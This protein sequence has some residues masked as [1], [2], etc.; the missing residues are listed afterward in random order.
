[1]SGEP[2]G[3]VIDPS[4]GVFS[5]T[6]DESQGPGGYSFVV[7][8]SDG[9]YSTSAAVKLTVNEVPT[10]PVIT[11]LGD[12]PMNI[13]NDSDPY[14]FVEPGY[15]AFDAE[16]GDLTGSVIVSGFVQM[17][18]NGTY[19]LTYS[20]TDSTDLT[21]VE[22]RIVNVSTDDSK[23]RGAFAGGGKVLGATTSTEEIIPE[24]TPSPEP[25]GGGQ[26]LGAQTC[27]I[28]ISGYIFA[29]ADNNPEDVRILQQFLNSHE[30]ENLPV[31]GF[32]GPLTQAAVSRFQVKY[33]IDV[34]RPWLPFGLFSEYL[35]TGNVGKTT[36]R[37]INMLLCPGTDI[38]MPQLP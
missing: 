20:V 35:P 36:L 13:F 26:V 5:W 30:G 9:A 17:N 18:L 27:E 32:Y 4:T 3:A 37:L 29:G 7:I 21:T 11:L 1:L 10:Y 25:Q 16:D 14:S 38:P 33:H 15:T 28:Q 6:P 24:A 2:S 23:G 22:T 34:L 8:A 12:N 19:T 31:N